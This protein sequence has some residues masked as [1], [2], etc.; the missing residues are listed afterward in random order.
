M[1]PSNFGCGFAVLAAMAI[2][3]PSYAALNAIAKPIPLDAP[4]I[5]IVLPFKLPAF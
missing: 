3:A 1:V 5:N 2:L 4:E